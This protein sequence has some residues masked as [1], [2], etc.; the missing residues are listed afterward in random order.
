VSAFLIKKDAVKA[1]DDDLPFEIDFYELCAN[2]WRSNEDVALDETLRPTVPNGFAYKVTT[3]GGGNLGSEEPEYPTTLGQTVASGSVT[4]ECVAAAGNGISDLSSPVATVTPPGDLA[5]EDLAV[6]E[7]RKLI[8]VYSGGVLGTKYEV[9][10]AFD[11]QGN[12]RTARQLV[13]LQKQ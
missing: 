13:K 5:V 6:S 8:G 10:F 9:A 7:G 2:V 3:T 12:S 1:P 4:L 11:F